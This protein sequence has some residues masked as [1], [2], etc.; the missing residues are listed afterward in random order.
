M[1]NAVGSVASIKLW[2][3]FRM[4]IELS[5][6]RDHHKVKLHGRSLTVYALRDNIT[7]YKIIHIRIHIAGFFIL[8]FDATLHRIC[9]GKEILVELILVL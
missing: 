5:C 2:T 1:A 8:A 7:T 3:L 4:N 6:T 9:I